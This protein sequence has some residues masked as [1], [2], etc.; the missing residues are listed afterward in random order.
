[1]QQGFGTQ[2]NSRTYGLLKDPLGSTRFGPWPVKMQ[3]TSNYQ[4]KDNSL[5]ISTY[6]LGHRYISTINNS[7]PIYFI[8]FQIFYFL[9]CVI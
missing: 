7:Y 5:E 1:M 2:T 6:I 8:L 9:L 3:S 4:S